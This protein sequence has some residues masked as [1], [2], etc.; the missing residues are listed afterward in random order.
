[1][2]LAMAGSEM[3]LP[4]S[5]STSQIVPVNLYL[6]QLLAVIKSVVVF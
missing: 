6:A 3:A 2:Y 4:F 1:M 5:F